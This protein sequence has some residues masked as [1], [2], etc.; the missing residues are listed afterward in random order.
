VWSI[1][2]VHSQ[3]GLKIWT[4]TATWTGPVLFQ[5]VCNKYKILFSVKRMHS[6]TFRSMYCV[7]NKETACQTK[8]SSHHQANNMSKLV[9]YESP[10][11][12][13]HVEEGEILALNPAQIASLRSN[14]TLKGKVAIIN[15]TGVL[16]YVMSTLAL[17]LIHN[18]N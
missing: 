2:S 10:N 5:N 4:L 14:T 3:N 11:R 9:R 7:P 6:E 17:P 13:P 16:G 12:L 18:I 15:L 1:Y 8:Y